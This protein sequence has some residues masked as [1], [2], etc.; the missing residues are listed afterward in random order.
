M[1]LKKWSNNKIAIS[2]E[3]FSLWVTEKLCRR[4][5]KAWQ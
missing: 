1:I 5:R 2:N 4:S 3:E